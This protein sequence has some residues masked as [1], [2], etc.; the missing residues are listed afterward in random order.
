MA[1]HRRLGTNATWYLQ[2]HFEWDGLSQVSDIKKTL[3]AG[4]KPL[5][6]DSIHATLKPLRVSPIGLVG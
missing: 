1:F 4:I 5:E 3:F 6:D 2:S